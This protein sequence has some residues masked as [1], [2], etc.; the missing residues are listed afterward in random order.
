MMTP[1]KVDHPVLVFD[2]DCG[3]CRQTVARLKAVTGE[4]IEYLP[5]QDAGERFAA[6]PAELFTRSVHLVE[7]NG[8]VTRA[9]EAVFRTLAI[10]GNRR[11]MLWCYRHVPLFAPFSEFGYRAVARLRPVFSSIANIFHG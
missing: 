9:A 2:G 11:G 10:G 8:R 5:F 3:F 6:I 4:R 1:A 7:P